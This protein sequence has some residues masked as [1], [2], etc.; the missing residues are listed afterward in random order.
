[1]GVCLRGCVSLAVTLWRNGNSGLLLITELYKL[2]AFAGFVGVDYGGLI[3]D[4]AY[5]ITW[6]EVSESACIT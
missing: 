1:M 2:C 6:F 5:T 3:G 4:D